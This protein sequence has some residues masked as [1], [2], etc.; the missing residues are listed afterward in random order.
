MNENAS[1]SEWLNSARPYN[2]RTENDLEE[3]LFGLPDSLAKQIATK[4]LSECRRLQH[5]IDDPNYRYSGRIHRN[6]ILCRNAEIRSK[7]ERITVLEDY[8][9]RFLKANPDYDEERK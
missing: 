5:E 9:D 4:L 3:I 6:A 7:T 8:I 2:A 1:V